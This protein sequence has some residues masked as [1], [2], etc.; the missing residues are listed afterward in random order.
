MPSKE[1]YFDAIVV[2]GGFGGV[3]QLFK[4]R[5]LGFKVKGF[6][7][8]SQLG[9]VWYWNTYPGARVDSDAPVYQLWL[10]DCY[11]DWTFSQRFPPGQELLEYF[12]HVDK[13]LNISKD[14]S[15]NTFVS[16]ASFDPITGLWTVLTRK[17][18]STDNM[19]NST[20]ES[21]SSASPPS[22]NGDSCHEYDTYKTKN[23]IICSGFAAK[24]YIPDI[25]H[26]KDFKGKLHHTAQWPKD[27]VDMKNKKVAIIGT[28][29]SGVQVIQEI[30]SEVK[31]LTV[32]QRTPNMAIPMQQ[33]MLNKEEE[34]LKK[35][36]LPQLWEET[37]RLSNAG[38]QYRFDKRSALDVSPEERE[39]FYSQLYERGGF[40]FWVGTFYDAWTNPKSDALQYDFW[41]RR[42]WQRVK[43]PKVAEKLAPAKQRFTLCSKRPSLEQHYYEVFNQ[44]NV[45]LIDVNEEKIECFTE[46]GIKT[47]DRE[48][49]FDIIILATGFDAVT[50][51]LT[52]INITGLENISLKKKWKQGVNTYLGVCTSW[53]PNMY[54]MY[55]PQ[56][57]TA[58]SNGPTCAQVQ[59][60]WITDAIIYCKRNNLKYMYASPES[61]AA[62]RYHVNQLQDLTL[63]KGS[64]YSWYVGSNIP[65]KTVE[66][67]MYLGGLPKYLEEIGVEADSS[68]K[69][70]VKVAK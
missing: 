48:L 41:R 22:I 53:F 51:G 37:L 54:F 50:G 28:G 10:E 14:F 17:N 63:L 34:D 64:K 19:E 59:A 13:K 38:F 16:D 45:E 44:D 24:I 15:F 30:A 35:P 58:F 62:W 18:E 39:R 11:T 6:E 36:Y 47:S 29:A 65:G 32:F 49:E 20:P 66:A 61:E 33:K 7:K 3:Y 69:N 40:N 1:H 70:F 57:P 55:G 67:L 8:G 42:V 25:P 12:K 52:Q 5:S 27:G 21:D 43:D 60:D 23:L 68:Y 46:K 2:G 56:G 4:L 31:H 9:G 26:M